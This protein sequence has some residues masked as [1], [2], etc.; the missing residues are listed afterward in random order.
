[1]GRKTT[2][3][4][5]NGPQSAMG[6]GRC[7]VLSRFLAKYFTNLCKN[8]PHFLPYTSPR[9]SPWMERCA[10]FK[11]SDKRKM[12]EDSSLEPYIWISIGSTTINLVT[13]LGSQ[14]S[15]VSGLLQNLPILFK[16][17]FLVN[18][19]IICRHQLIKC[20]KL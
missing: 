13:G 15:K 5:T 20:E 19:W 4:Q 14:F 11:P 7:A 8:V 6:R 17:L 9:E 16:L 10:V 2:S 12:R 3:K 1:M 18:H